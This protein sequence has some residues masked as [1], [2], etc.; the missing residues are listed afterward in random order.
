MDIDPHSPECVEMQKGQTEIVL[1][2][3]PHGVRE[4]D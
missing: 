4:E 2:L 3:R 1:M